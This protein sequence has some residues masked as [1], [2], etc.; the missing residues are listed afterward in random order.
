MYISDRDRSS[1]VRPETIIYYLRIIDITYNIEVFFSAAKKYSLRVYVGLVFR[2]DLYRPSQDEQKRSLSR[3]ASVL[4]C[5]LCRSSHKPSDQS[6]IFLSG[7]GLGPE[8]PGIPT[9]CS[10]QRRVWEEIRAG[11]EAL[12]C[13]V[14]CF[15]SL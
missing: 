14:D 6:G 2:H 5:Y 15:P 10:T 12:G 13:V 1:E 4:L 11:A 9:R 8:S 7:A 3:Q